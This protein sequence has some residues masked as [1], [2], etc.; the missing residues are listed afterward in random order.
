MFPD[1]PKEYIFREIAKQESF[2]KGFV[3]LGGDPLFPANIEDAIV[4]A[5]HLKKYNKPITM[6]TGY[7]EREIAQNDRRTL[8]ASLCDK[9]LA[10][11][12]VG[13]EKQRGVA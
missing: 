1:W 8:A 7:T 13:Q 2:V 11:R 6:L 10:G 4:L 3:L 9:V 5:T 12:Y